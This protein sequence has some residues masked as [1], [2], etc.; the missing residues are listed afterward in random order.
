VEQLK[1][2]AAA[3]VAEVTTRTADVAA[4]KALIQ[5]LEPHGPGDAALGKLREAVAALEEVLGAAQGRSKAAG[6]AVVS[7][8]G[9]VAKALAAVEA[10]KARAMALPAEIAARATARDDAAKIAAEAASAK[11][12][13]LQPVAAAEQ[14]LAEVEATYAKAWGP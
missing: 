9:E 5:S 7:A 8:E 4:T 10:G 1:T 14:K 3:V 12:A 6:E 2:A 13:A 11:A